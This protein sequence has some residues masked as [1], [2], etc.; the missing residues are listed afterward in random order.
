MSGPIPKRTMTSIGAKANNGAS[1]PTILSRTYARMASLKSTT[2]PMVSSIVSKTK[3]A[4]AIQSAH[5]REN[6]AAN[7]RIL[8][9]SMITTMTMMASLTAATTNTTEATASKR[10]PAFVVSA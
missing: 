3:V 6:A 8:K 10:N 4:I 5:T 9:R 2:I 1:N 7:G